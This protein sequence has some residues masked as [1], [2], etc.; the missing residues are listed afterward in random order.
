MA[1]PPRNL[2][3]PAG[4]PNPN[5]EPG[6]VQ[7]RQPK[8]V[9]SY[10]LAGAVD[11]RTGFRNRKMDIPFYNAGDNSIK[12]KITYDKIADLDD[13]KSKSTGIGDILTNR[14][15]L[16]YYPEFYEYL[17]T[18]HFPGV[19]DLSAAAYE[20]YEN[21]RTMFGD[22]LTIGY[23]DPVDPLLVAAGKSV[24]IGNVSFLEF[25]LDNN[26]IS[27]LKN[28][29]TAQDKISGKVEALTEQS[30]SI[31]VISPAEIREVLE[32]L[33]VLPSFEDALNLFNQNER[34]SHYGD[35]TT[36][37]MANYLQDSLIVNDVLKAFAEQEGRL[38]T[39]VLPISVD[40]ESVRTTLPELLNSV[41]LESILEE[42][43]GARLTAENPIS[44]E[45]TFLE[46]NASPEGEPTGII[47]ISFGMKSPEGYDASTGS[48]PG[49]P[50]QSLA[51]ARI[52]YF[53]K[54]ERSALKTGYM[55]NS[56]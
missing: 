34:I 48:Q 26:Q 52:S 49:E 55:T 2:P 45:S 18:P 29:V 4:P 44:E 6:V 51:I 33:D 47:F 10:S 22:A 15:I 46:F 7:A 39:N 30:T 54:D 53:A 56:K 14:L 21:I 9:Q 25:P 13:L 24:I 11:E 27:T 8:P 42:L 28:E 43:Q 19:V 5:A 1:K 37:L 20:A 41:I 12:V 36:L 31:S 38:G 23:Y 32:I 16:H 3:A 35:E 50:E 17:P 40:F